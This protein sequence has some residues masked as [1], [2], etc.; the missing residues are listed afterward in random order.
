MK[1]FL[2]LYFTIILLSSL[3]INAQTK[4]NRLNFSV[5]TG[6]A[7]YTMD[8]LKS[9][10]SYNAS[11]LP[12][13]LKTINN[14]NPGF[15]FGGSL[16]T[17]IFPDIFLVIFYQYHTTGSRIGQKDYSGY[18]TF[19][20]IVNG[21]LVGIEPGINIVS[22]EAFNISSSIQVGA[23]FSTIEMNEDRVVL[24]VENQASQ[25]LSAFSIVISPSVKLS[26]PVFK[27]VD[28]FFSLGAMYDTGG[29][30]HLPDKKDAVLVIDGAQVKT[31]WSGWKIAIGLKINIMN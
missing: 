11:I 23:L 16:Q 7:S 5:Y 27:S 6:S 1:P 15:Y 14:F 24:G 28:C 2:N 25:D 30:I 10:N 20:Q 22:K 9:I 8:N 31:E 29:T 26:V 18:Y 13:N 19:D 12:F 3:S 4:L 17:R 21:N